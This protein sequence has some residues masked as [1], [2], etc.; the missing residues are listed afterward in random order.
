[1]NHTW[2]ALFYADRRI[3]SKDN[4]FEEAATKDL[5]S[6]PN[7][8]SAP[9]AKWNTDITINTVASP[10]VSIVCEPEAMQH[11]VAHSHGTL[12]KKMDSCIDKLTSV[13]LVS[14]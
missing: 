3:W 1:M 12:P 2:P 5:H 11:A 9:M 4:M 6:R 13:L 14:R 8:S 7:G 10:L